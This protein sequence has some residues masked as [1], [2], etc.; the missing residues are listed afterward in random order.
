MI[1]RFREM[2][3]TLDAYE[4]LLAHS[5]RKSTSI[6]TTILVTSES[7]VTWTVRRQVLVHFH[8]VHKNDVRRI[9]RPVAGHV[10]VRAVGIRHLH[11]DTVVPM[12]L[13]SWNRRFF[14]VPSRLQDPRNAVVLRF[15]ESGE[16]LLSEYL[17]RSLRD[18]GVFVRVFYH[19]CQILRE[20]FPH[21]PWQISDCFDGGLAKLRI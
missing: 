20:A 9:A 12:M 17:P 3:A 16:K 6:F 11:Y 14:P 19:M 1:F 8:A 2:L 15:R 10:A 18:P 4:R 5:R 13:T 7:A 21:V